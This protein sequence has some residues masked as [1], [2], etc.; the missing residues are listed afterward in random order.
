MLKEERHKLIMKEI[1]L[2]NKV[3]SVDLSL[4]LNV[5]EDTVRRDLKELSDGSKIL[6]VHGGAINKSL[7]A[8]FE[9]DSNIYAIEAK[10][11]IAKKAVALLQDDMIILLEGGTTI[12][13]FAK[14]IPKNIRLTVLTVSP[15]TALVLAENRNLKVI[16]IGGELKKK[17][18]IHTGAIVINQLY[19]FKADLCFMGVNALSVKEGLTDIDWDI[20]Q[21]NKAMIKNS[22]KTI[23]LTIAEKLNITKKIKVCDI[24]NVDCLITE[25]NSDDKALKP[26]VRAGVSVL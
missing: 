18:N 20:S 16:T 14:A 9:S 19:G 25:L 13:E 21:V 5:S 2:H 6:R 8:Q 1:N 4:L 24:N 22:T 3:L 11:I 10:Q 12:L 26:Y 7:I 15:H 23:L 17:S